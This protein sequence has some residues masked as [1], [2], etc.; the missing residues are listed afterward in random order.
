MSTKKQRNIAAWVPRLGLL[1]VA[2]LAVSLISGSAATV[3]AAHPLLGQRLGFEASSSGT[4][5]LEGTADPKLLT[6]TDGGA[7][8]AV[9]FG[10]F[11]YKRLVLENSTIVPTWCD[12]GIGSTAVYGSAVIVFA[13]GSLF[14]EQTSGEACINPGIVPPAVTFVTKNKITG[15][16]GLFEGAKG[17]LAIEAT[18]D[19]FASSIDATF[20]GSI[21]LDDD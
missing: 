15:G 5:T 20:S 9:D 11:T 17:K 4:F 7:G 14:L 21:K 1:L 2:V 12:T 10:A 3:A 19:F 6:V 18:G 13:D 8:S 16:T